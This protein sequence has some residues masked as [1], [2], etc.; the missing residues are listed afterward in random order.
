MRKAES[1]KDWR[2]SSSKR[3]SFTLVVFRGIGKLLVVVKRKYV[4]LALS[5][6]VYGL[7]K[8]TP[9]LVA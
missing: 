7:S 8:S 2:K 5:Q 6:E 1:K 4:I 9:P 3:K